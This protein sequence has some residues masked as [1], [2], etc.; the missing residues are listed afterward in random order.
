M[1]KTDAP[2]RA[3]ACGWSSN[4]WANLESIALSSFKP[5]LPLGAFGG[6]VF[7]DEDRRQQHVH[8]CSSS[9]LYPLHWPIGKFLK[10]CVWGGFLLFAIVD[11]KCCSSI[12]FA[13]D[14]LYHCKQHSPFPKKV[15]QCEVRLQ[16]PSTVLWCFS[17][18]PNKMD[19][20]KV[21]ISVLQRKTPSWLRHFYRMTREEL[22]IDLSPTKKL[23]AVQSIPL[24]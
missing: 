2:L 23:E 11:A 21:L 1:L 19:S 10:R 8:P 5:G 18:L 13:A 14:L 17:L 9:L 3:A 24:S 16:V 7:G 15:D 20:E 22:E 12:S 6:S 4:H